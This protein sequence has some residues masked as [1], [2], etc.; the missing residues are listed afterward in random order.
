VIG[1]PLFDLVIPPKTKKQIETKNIMNKNKIVKVGVKIKEDTETGQLYVA[2]MCNS[3]G[4]DSPRLAIYAHAFVLL[5]SDYF[6][7]ND[8]I[9][10][11]IRA[12]AAEGVGPEQF[13][14]IFN[15]FPV[16]KPPTD[17]DKR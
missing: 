9:P 11:L 2:L 7:T 1:S 13:G 3:A 8:F 6:D 17:G 5:L 16:V 15:I 10:Y 4:A 12:A 14:R